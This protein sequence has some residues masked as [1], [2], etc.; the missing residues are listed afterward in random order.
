MGVLM[1]FKS[2]VGLTTLSSASSQTDHLS[3]RLYTVPELLDLTKLSR[4]QIAYWALIDLLVPTLK[5]PG[6]RT[7]S[8]SSFYSAADVVKAL[9][10]C[11]LRKAGFSLRQIQQVAKNL[12]ERKIRLDK[13]ENYLLTDG[14]SVY[15]ANSDSEAL[16]MLK[17]YRQMLLLIPIHEQVE[18]LRR[19]A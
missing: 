14:Y 4:K 13:S 5:D 12:E 3:K 2:R 6:A 9:V 16:D 19:A 8:P 15:Y 7:G 10:F 1:G 17:H 18:K 11:D